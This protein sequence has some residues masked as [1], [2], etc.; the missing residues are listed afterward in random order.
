M[1]FFHFSFL[2]TI[3][4][5]TLS[6]TSCNQEDQQKSKQTM[7]L[8]PAQVTVIRAETVIATDQ[9]EVVGTLQAVEKA[10]ISSKITGNITKLTIDLGSTVQKGELLAEISAGEISAQV[11]QAKAQYEQ[12]KRNLKREENLLK[13]NAATQEGVKSYKDQRK[14]AEA[15]YNE[16]LTMLEYTKITAPFSGIVTR[17]FASTGDLATPGKPLIHIEKQGHLEVQT[18]IPEAM[19]LTIQK[20]DSLSVY[21]PASDLRITGSVAEVS[22]TA[23]PTSRTAPIK[24]KIDPNPKLRSGQFARITLVTG[25]SKTLMIPKTAVVAFGQMQRVFVEQDGKARLRLVRTGIMTEET[26]EILSGLEEGDTIIVTGNQKL[27]D[28]QSVTVQ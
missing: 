26:I 14:I 5:V 18:A 28:G 10:E 24:L 16:A 1:R 22:P 21:V 23:D 12:A 20:G 8:P 7:V 27:V 13:K 9:A 6:L 25:E 15:L 2:V 17:K 4:A 3:L 19:I 11:Q